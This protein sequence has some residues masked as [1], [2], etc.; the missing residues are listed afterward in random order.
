MRHLLFYPPTA[1]GGRRGFYCQLIAL[2]PFR[3]RQILWADGPH[4][5]PD[6]AVGVVPAVY[7]R[8]EVEVA[9]VEAAGRAERTR[10]V[11]A[12]AAGIEEYG[13]FAVA[14]GRQEDGVAVRAIYLLELR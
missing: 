14:G 13:T 9:G 4:R 6:V 10:P 3:A 5:E 12:F 7:V 8:T 1:V 11:V 2:C